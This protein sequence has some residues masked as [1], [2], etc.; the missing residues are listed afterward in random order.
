MIGHRLTKVF[1]HEGYDHEWDWD[2]GTLAEENQHV[3]HMASKETIT[4]G[5][6][7]KKNGRTINRQVQRSAI[8]AVPVGR[9]RDTLIGLRDPAVPDVVDQ[10]YYFIESPARW[11][12]I[13]I[14]VGMEETATLRVQRASQQEDDDEEESDEEESGDEHES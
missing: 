2:H 6:A 12:E 13:F 14:R 10:F 8:L 7:T 9:I 3:I 5:H 4:I 1:C 11:S